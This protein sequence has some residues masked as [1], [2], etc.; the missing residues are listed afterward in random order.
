MALWI[1]PLWRTMASAV[2]PLSPDEKAVLWFP[3][4]CLCFSCFYY[5][6]YD[7]AVC[8]TTVLPTDLRHLPVL[9][10]TTFSRLCFSAWPG[11]GAPLSRDLEGALY[12]FCLVDWIAYA[13]AVSTTFFCDVCTA[14]AYATVFVLQLFVLLLFYA[15]NFKLCVLVL[16]F[17]MFLL[18]TT[19]E[20]ELMLLH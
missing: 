18:G 11:S 12:K 16:Q 13:A 4:S 17:F 1:E 8:T 14:A 20:D 6:C 15:L 5:S 10:A 2:M 9:N 19:N 3:M 7:V